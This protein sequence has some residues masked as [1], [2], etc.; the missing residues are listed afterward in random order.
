MQN[1]TV[2]PPKHSI[3]RKSYSL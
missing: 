2:I 3:F 1:N